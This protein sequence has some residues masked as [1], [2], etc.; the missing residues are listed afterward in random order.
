M[1]QGTTS[2]SASPLLERIMEQILLEVMLRH[3]EEREVISDN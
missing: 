2:L 1:I 3:M